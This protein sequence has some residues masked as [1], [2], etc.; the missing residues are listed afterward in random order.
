MLDEVRG[1]NATGYD[2]KELVFLAELGRIIAFL[3]L[4]CIFT[5]VNLFGENFA[6]FHLR[7]L[8]NAMHLNSLSLLHIFVQSTGSSQLLI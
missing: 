1:E 3:A 6:G 7:Q 5:V 8:S 4:V 2:V